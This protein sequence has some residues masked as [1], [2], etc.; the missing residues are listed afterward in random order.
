MLTTQTIREFVRA[1][2]PTP[3]RLAPEL[4]FSIVMP[5]FNQ[6]RFIERSL[7]SV[8]NQECE[9]V[10][11]IV[12]D[13]G[14]KDGT[15]EIL[16]RYSRHIALWRSE[17]D[18]GQ[19]AALNKG[20][21]CATG[22]IYGWLNS[23]DLYLPG[24]L[25]HAAHIFAA[26]PQIDAVY[27]DWFEIDE[28]EQIMERCPALA[29]SRGRLVTEGFFCNAQAMFWRR[30]LHRR[31]GDFDTQLHYTMDYDLMLRMI[32][33][34]GPSAFFRADRPLGCFRVYPGQKTGSPDPRAQARVHEEHRRIAERAGTRWK[35]ALR[36]RAL[37][38]AYRLTRGAEY[39]SLKRR[40]L[41]MLKLKKRFGVPASG[42]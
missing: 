34:A 32:S 39:L 24:A 19:S 28:T 16:Q 41:F 33:A 23:D 42:R 17:P 3:R 14:S 15:R 38:L 1:P 7:N 9:G 37:R 30:S 13:G 5:S 35:Y 29:P 10:E 20:F 22:E 36:G 40:D 6:A 18:E 8:I 4:R 31:L 21:A 27:G 26:H 2:M 11:L 25:H 12:M